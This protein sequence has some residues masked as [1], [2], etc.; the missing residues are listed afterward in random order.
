MRIYLSILVVHF[1]LFQP[2]SAQVD[3]IPQSLNIDS[4]FAFIQGYSQATLSKLK[5]HFDRVKDE[6]L[7]IL[8]YG[9]SHIQAE[10]PTTVAR[11]KFHDQFGYGGRGLLFN[12]GAANTYSS[13]NYS[14]TFTGK[15]KYN[16]SFQGK[17]VDLPLGICGMVVETSDSVAALNFKM[18][19]PIVK[20]DY[21]CFL[22][23]ENDSLSH[24][25][26]MFINE[27]EIT[28]GMRTYPYGVSF[29][30]SDSITSIRIEVVK[31]VTSKRFRFY[32]LNIEN[33]KNS[34]VV[35]HST[36]VGA[37]AFRSILTLEKIDVQAPVI[38]PD[39]VILD[40]GTNDILYHNKIDK[41]LVKEVEKSIKLWRSIH[42]EIL[43]VLTS[44]QDLYYKKKYITAGILFRDLMDSLA[45]K[46]DCLF[47]NW[48]D[49]SGGIKTIRTW[50]NEGYAQSDCI[51]LTKKGYQ[52]K[53]GLL[54]HSF[55]QTLDRFSSN[56]TM[57]ELTIPMKDY[58]TKDT[59]TG[60]AP[61]GID[62]LEVPKPQVD[63]PNVTPK[64]KYHVVKSGDTLSQ[65]AQKYHTTISKLKALNNLSRTT[66]R[67]GQRLKIPIR[68]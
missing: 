34:G 19:T 1:F 54:Y 68:T 46:N 39:I 43:V 22:F 64:V 24:G 60:Q 47:W 15:W 55:I 32:G 6:K 26:R 20:E 35:Y 45:R 5:S 52:V 51:H 9:G 16:K 49:L 38:Q 8:H 40:F 2:V 53:G 31:T 25:F 13:V 41:N 57:N 3:D 4:N 21:S 58:S 36:G 18:K 10:N 48:Y 27:K 63:R 62:S 56:A 17:K 7:V 23:F 61:L 59:L 28:T 37:A 33:V 44:T 30:F 67:I 11:K 14:S 42:P 29:P 66:I 50:Y 12:Y 65:I